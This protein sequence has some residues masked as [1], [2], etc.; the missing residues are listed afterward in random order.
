MT[1]IDVKH[2]LSNYKE[3]SKSIE[4]IKDKI[5]EI[6]TKQTK[7]GGSIIK[8]PENNDSNEQYKLGLIEKKSKYE[9]E[10]SIYLYYRQLAEDFISCLKSPW[11][12]MVVEK[13]I[14]KKP[15]NILQKNYSYSSRQ[16]FNIINKLIELYVEET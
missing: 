2:A 13:F 3:I 7:T 6:E 14:D 1:D 10:L 4:R 11:R 9:F 16:L 15:M 8:M 12:E 5:L